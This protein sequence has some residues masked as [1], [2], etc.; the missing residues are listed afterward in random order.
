MIASTSTIRP[1]TLQDAQSLVELMNFAG[2]G[3]PFYVWATMAKGSE[4]DPWSIGLARARREEGSF[5]YRNATIIEEDRAVAGCLV[6]YP[7]SDEPEA[8][9]L[10]LPEMFV[11]L[12]QLENLAPGTWY[13]NALA[14]YPQ[15]RK[16]GFGTALLKHAEKL[17]VTTP[18]KRGMSVIVADN[19]VAA[20]RL[21]ERMGYRHLADR[22]M[23]K[24]RW[25]SRG[26]AWVLLVKGSI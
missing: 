2:E 11:P 22:P 26:S 24:G 12:Q 20:R 13:V 15:Y 19:N 9:E 21:Y 23:I 8:I 16:K 6:G 7:R 18:A 4:A 5:S 25:E 17:A 1:A 14:I 10:S 3:L